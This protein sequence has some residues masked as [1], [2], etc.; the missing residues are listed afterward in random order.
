MK[1]RTINRG[2]KWRVRLASDNEHIQDGSEGI[3]QL[4]Q[5]LRGTSAEVQRLIPRHLLVLTGTRQRGQIKTTQQPD[6]FQPE[7]ETNS[8]S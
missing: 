3:L 2:V 4:F 8:L 1:Y 6:K 5:V 7:H